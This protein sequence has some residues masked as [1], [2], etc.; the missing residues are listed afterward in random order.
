MP[1]KIKLN[2]EDLEVQSFVTSLNAENA[3][4]FKGGANSLNPEDTE[5]VDCCRDLTL[6][7]S[8]CQLCGGGTWGDSQGG[9]VTWDNLCSFTGCPATSECV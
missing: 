3:L 1:K 2:L 5:N 7:R 4:G 8:S 6:P 9:C